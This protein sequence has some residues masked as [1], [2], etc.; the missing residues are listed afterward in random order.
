M[1]KRKVFISETLSYQAHPLEEETKKRK[2]E[3]K[4]ELGSNDELSWIK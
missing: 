1:R 2:K 3:K 4:L